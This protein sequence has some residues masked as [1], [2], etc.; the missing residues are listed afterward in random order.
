[1]QETQKISIFA[2]IYIAF[3]WGAT[4]TDENEKICTKSSLRDDVHDDSIDE[5][6]A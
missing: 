2:R 6:I 1:M 4:V 3:L 5:N